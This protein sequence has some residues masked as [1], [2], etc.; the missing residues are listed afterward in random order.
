MGKNSY[1]NL[2]FATL[3]A[4]GLYGKRCAVLFVPLGGGVFGV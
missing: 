3:Y 1:G 2:I 4:D